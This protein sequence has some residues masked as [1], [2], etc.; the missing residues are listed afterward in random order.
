MSAFPAIAGIRTSSLALQ[1]PF[2]M[3]VPQVSRWMFEPKEY[4]DSP[5]AVQKIIDCACF[6]ISGLKIYFVM[7]K[8]YGRETNQ[9]SIA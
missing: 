7:L 2:W 8:N 4:L 5:N 3:T 9:A 1:L 6:V